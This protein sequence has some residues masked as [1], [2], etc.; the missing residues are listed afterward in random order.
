MTAEHPT[1]LELEYHRLCQLE[2]AA[3]LAA[4]VRGG[5]PQNDPVYREA[6]RARKTHKATVMDA[7]DSFWRGPCLLTPAEQAI[8]REHGEKL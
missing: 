5:S 1:A 4:L 8:I 7:G 2:D 6:L 3:E